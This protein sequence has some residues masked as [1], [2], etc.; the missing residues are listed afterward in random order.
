MAGYSGTPLAKKL[1]IKPP[2]TLAAIDAPREYLTWL[3]EL[4]A[5]VRVV[6]KAGK[7][8]QAVRLFVTQRARLVEELQKYRQQL[9]QTGFVWVSWPKKAAKVATGCYNAIG[10]DRVPARRMAC[11]LLAQ[12]SRHWAA[13]LVG[14]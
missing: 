13:T 14:K 4:P 3:G 10:A 11:S 12:R 6:S 9:D 5:G 2:L 1:G 8:L 7:P